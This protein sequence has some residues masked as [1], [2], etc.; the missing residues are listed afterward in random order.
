MSPRKRALIARRK[1][2]PKR[3]SPRYLFLKREIIRV[4]DVLIDN[5]AEI[6]KRAAVS[7][8]IE[9][10]PAQWSFRL[11]SEI[12]RFLGRFIDSDTIFITHSYNET[13]KEYE[14]I[15]TPHILERKED[16]R[17]FIKPIQVRQRKSDKK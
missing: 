12:G 5:M 6:K 9:K 2:N 8:R 3:S 16:E 7:L 11:P 17:F 10:V 15:R 14:K 4:R 1:T 13:E